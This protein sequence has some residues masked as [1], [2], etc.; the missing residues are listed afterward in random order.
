MAK[1]K[2][3]LA[4]L[5]SI[6]TADHDKGYWFCLYTEGDDDYVEFTIKQLV[7]D[8]LDRFENAEKTVM[9]HSDDEIHA[10]KEEFIDALIYDLTSLKHSERM[11]HLRRKRLN[12]PFQTPS[13]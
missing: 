10:M 9:E 3:K 6:E 1:K 4:T 13:T 2:D 8:E 7:K 11:I 12:S 5:E